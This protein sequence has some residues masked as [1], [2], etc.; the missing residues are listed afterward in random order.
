M[1][2][3]GSNWGLKE[4]QL[5]QNTAARVVNGLNPAKASDKKWQGIQPTRSC[6]TEQSR[7][8]TVS[9][10]SH[11]AQEQQRASLKACEIT[12]LSSVCP[13]RKNKSPNNTLS[14]TSWLH[15]SVFKYKA[16]VVKLLCQLP[17]CK[18]VTAPQFFCPIKLSRRKDIYERVSLW[19]YESLFRKSGDADQAQSSSYGYLWSKGFSSILDITTSTVKFWCNSLVMHHK[20][21]FHLYSV[22]SNV[23]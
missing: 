5:H 9:C 4:T 2:P 18:T 20:I 7:E 12:N 10:Q 13:R 8:M 14:H 11:Q 21:S 1:V 17:D 6:E 22:H 19:F 3:P 23:V 15:S 16:G